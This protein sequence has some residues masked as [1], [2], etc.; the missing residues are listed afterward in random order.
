MN[1]RRVK[2]IDKLR[3]RYDRREGDWMAF[4][5]AGDRTFA[6]SA[7]LLSCVFTKDVRDE[8]TRRG[9]DLTS[10]RFEISPAAGSHRH[11]GG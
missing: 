3:Y 7:Y 10:I 4:H 11:Q 5:P 9:Y 2:A 6:D 8:L 1:T